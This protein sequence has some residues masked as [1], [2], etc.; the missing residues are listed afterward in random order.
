VQY[1]HLSFDDEA[2]VTMGTDTYDDGTN[3]GLLLQPYLESITSTT[4]DG[5][6]RAIIAKLLQEPELFAG[7]NQVKA[8]LGASADPKLI[9]TL[10]LF[11]YGTIADYSREPESYVALTEP[12]LNKLRQ[13]T[14]LSVI[15]SS[16]RKHQRIV[17]YTS[18]YE[19][20]FLSSPQAD[21]SNIVSKQLLLRETEQLLAPLIAARM[22]NGKF[23]QKQESLLLGIGSMPPTAAHST[24]HLGSSNM[25]RSSSYALVVQSRDVPPDAIPSLVQSIQEIRTRLRESNLVLRPEQP[26]EM[27]IVENEPKK[28]S[29]SD[30]ATNDPMI[31]DDHDARPPMVLTAKRGR[32]GSSGVQSNE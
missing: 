12:Q 10:D 11:S 21:L 32:D 24:S 4:T 13:L 5:V 30:L 19:A 6:Q 28:N 23:S 22:V 9:H 26:D 14:A 20:A 25:G 27:K 15:Q 29:D 3:T 8:M 7:Y 16:C 2:V 17:P 18:I 31:V 1:D